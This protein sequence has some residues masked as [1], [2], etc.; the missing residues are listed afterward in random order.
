MHTSRP[1]LFTVD[2]YHRLSDKGILSPDERSELLDGEILLMAAKKPPHSSI[3]QCTAD[4]LTK[5]LTGI[6]LVRR[7]EPVWPNSHSEP[8]PDIAVVRID[9]RRY[10]AHHPTPKD[11]FLLIEVADATLS[12]DRKKKASAYAKAGIFDYWVIDVKKER[13][14]VLRDPKGNTYQQ[15]VVY[16]K[17]SVLNPISLPDTQLILANFFP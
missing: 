13:V 6:A 3:T 9:D 12:Y 1:K 17:A 4:Y 14:F 16:G 11:I 8:E 5:L 10:F 7:Q 15:E 2:E